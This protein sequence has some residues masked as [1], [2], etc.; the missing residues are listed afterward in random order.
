MPRLLGAKAQGDTAEERKSAAESEGLTGI[1][2]EHVQGLLQDRTSSHLLEVR[3]S[4]PLARP[5]SPNLILDH[6]QE[7]L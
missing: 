4:S 3:N 5:F 1:A 7:L 2:K 6:A